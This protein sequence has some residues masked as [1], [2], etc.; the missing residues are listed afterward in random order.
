MFFDTVAYAQ[1]AVP[2][3][4]KASL[5]SSFLPLILIF[6]VFYFFIIRPQQKRQKTLVAM[7]DALKAGDEVLTTSGIYGTISSIV[8]TNTFLLEI[9]PNVKVKMAKGSIGSKVNQDIGTGDQST[10]ATPKSSKEKEKPSSVISKKSS[11]L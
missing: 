1:E 5:F 4:S 9:A 10:I 3:A 8:D 6:F 2:A 11:K 7:I